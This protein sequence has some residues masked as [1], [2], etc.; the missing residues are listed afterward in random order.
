[1]EPASS[2]HQRL[3]LDKSIDNS[4]YNTH[5]C[6]QTPSVYYVDVRATHISL[7]ETRRNNR[8][9]LICLLSSLCPQPRSFSQPLTSWSLWKG[10]FDCISLDANCGVLWASFEVQMGFISRILKHVRRTIMKEHMDMNIIVFFITSARIKL[11]EEKT[12]IWKYY[13]KSIKK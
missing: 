11:F 8:Y 2:S 5:Y 9:T 4:K 13:V 12:N 6:S 10:C 3:F 7:E 1:M